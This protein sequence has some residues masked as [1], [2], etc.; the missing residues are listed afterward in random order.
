[1]DQAACGPFKKTYVAFS[2]DKGTAERFIPASLKQSVNK[3]LEG[4]ARDVR[5][6]LEG[7]SPP[8]PPETDPDGSEPE[9]QDD[10]GEGDG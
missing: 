8:R 5:D 9:A 1:M 2:V 10:E 4:I 7:K 6:G 3:I